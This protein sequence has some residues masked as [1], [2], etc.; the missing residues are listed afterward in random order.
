MIKWIKR[1]LLFII[2]IF[3]VKK[4]YK[5]LP[6]RLEYFGHYDKIWS[7]RNNSI[8]KANTALKYFKG[9]ELDLMYNKK[10][11]FLDVNH[12]PAKSI[13]LSFHNYI[14]NLDKQPYLWL[15]IKN[16]KLEN[17][18][19]ILRILNNIFSENNYPKNKVLIETRF[20][21]ALPVFEKNGYKT[22]YY[23]PYEMYKFSNKKLDSSIQKI[24]SMLRHQP[25]VGVSFNYLDY[26][27]INK[28]FPNRQKYI[29][30]IDGLLSRNYKLAKKTL[31]DTNVKVVLINYKTKSHR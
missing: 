22:I 20:P 11:D 1:I 6:Y 27:I 24:K 17:T 2:V 14:K 10:E 30:M 21:K 18:E 25:N 3:V 23:L 29:W 31:N 7:H 28:H 13:N 26:T 12:P 5:Y 9:I 16:L 8:A 15:D 19:E 4:F